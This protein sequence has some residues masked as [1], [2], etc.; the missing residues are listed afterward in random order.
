M[1]L[2]LLAMALLKY[3][4]RSLPT[5]KDTGIG[6]TKQVNEAVGEE[7]RRQQSEADQA[8]PPRKR[9]EYTIFSSEQ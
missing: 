6:D 9:K 1:H 5:A 4:S 2:A 8:K 3:F 7:L